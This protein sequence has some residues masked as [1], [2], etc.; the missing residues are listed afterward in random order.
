MDIVWE[1]KEKNLVKAER[2]VK[3]AA[4]GKV[5]LLLFPEMTLTGFSMNTVKTAESN[6]ESVRNI[7]ELAVRFNV[8][9]GFGWVESVFGGMARNHYTVVSASG[10]EISDYVKIHPFSY[11]D[12]DRH[13]VS[14]DSV[15]I[16]S[17]GG[18]VVSTFICYDLRFPEVFQAVSKRAQLII[19][20]ASWPRAR[21]DHWRTLLRARAIENQ[22]FIAGVNCTGDKGGI[23]YSGDT[24]LVDPRGNII[25]ES[26]GTEELLSA[27]INVSSVD[28]Y[29]ETF[30]L[31]R[32]RKNELY[33]SI[34]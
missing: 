28:K 29:R 9:I 13:F 26:V 3:E 14:G 22:V 27:E 33:R 1:D 2:F 16:F 11:A 31:K 25:K 24:M 7:S 19:V 21:K 6:R 23:N 30:P 4:D 34:L 15:K 8:S 18:F 20:A 12:E 32:D 5:E 17:T 10:G